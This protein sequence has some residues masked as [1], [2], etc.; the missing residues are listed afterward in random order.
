MEERL[1]DLEKENERLRKENSALLRKLA[2][3]AERA[4]QVE[5]NQHK[6]PASSLSCSAHNLRQDVL[7]LPTSKDSQFS[8]A[9][10]EIVEQ[11]W[12]STLQ[13]IVPSHPSCIPVEADPQSPPHPMS[14]PRDHIFVATSDPST[15]MESQLDPTH[16]SIN[17]AFV[18][19][20]SNYVLPAASIHPLDTSNE[21]FWPF[22]NAS[23]YQMRDSHRLPSVNASG[24]T[25][26][27]ASLHP[28]DTSNE[29][30]WPFPNA[31]SYQMRDSHRLPSV[32]ASSYT[33]PAAS[34]HPFDTS[35][36]SFWPFPN[37]SSYQMRDSH[38]LPSVN[39]SSYT[40]PVASLHPFDTSNESFWPFPNASSYQMRDSHHLPSVNASS[41]ALPVASLHPFD[42]SDESFWP[43]PKPSS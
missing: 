34:L 18:N 33:L 28:L 4:N 13:S 37:A 15:G 26:P 39:A 7:D 30:F 5:I 21:S 25:L 8:P 35:N 24:Y 22:P 10:T 11:A 2:R 23:S 12:Q 27:V 41:Y 42:T 43:F 1:K 38:R 19:V 20:A 6:A 36:E 16:P 32:N 31:S 14:E 9:A 29:S 40:L 3:A 17:D